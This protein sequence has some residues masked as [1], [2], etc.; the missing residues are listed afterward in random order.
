[1][2]KTSALALGLVLVAGTAL[3]S[4]TGFKLNYTL[5]KPGTTT[6]NNWVSPPYFYY[7][8]GNVSTT[9]VQN[10]IDFCNDVNEFQPNAPK[11]KQ[12][13]RYNP[14]TDKA[15]NQSCVSTIKV[16]DLKVGETYS[17]IPTADNIVV[18]LVGSH[19]DKY[20]KNKTPTGTSLYFLRKPTASLT[21][22][23]WVSV[24]YHA[25]ANNSV[26]LCK[27]SNNLQFSD[28]PTAPIVKQ[29]FRYNPLTDKA[30]VQSCTSA[31]RSYDIVPGEGYSMIPAN[32]NV[33]I[34][35]SV[36]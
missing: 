33:G 10:A 5:R 11:V 12:I 3:A 16:Y 4:N 14:L 6:G 29:I 36:Y 13:F 35:I 23:N 18:N 1:M 7:P 28:P 32:D 15:L 27:D 8:N 22:N 2:R 20:A 17:L 34:S 21:G 26:D 9:T 25:L 31:I 24:P 30:L 19:D